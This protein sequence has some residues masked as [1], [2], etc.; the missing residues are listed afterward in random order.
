MLK[1]RIITAVILCVTLIPALFL[2]SDVAWATLV[3][4]I[5]LLSMYEWSKLT[6]LN[7]P[8]MMTAIFLFACIGVWTLLQVHHDSYHSFSYRGLSV[9]AVAA[10]FWLLLVPV[11][12][13]K[14]FEVRNKILMVLLGLLLLTSFLFA[15]ILVRK[16]DPWLLLVLLVTIWVADSAAYF[17]GKQF[18]KNKL[19]P[20]IS[21]GKTWE[22]VFGALVGVSAFA[23]ILY[24]GFGIKELA[25]FPTFWVMTLLGIMGDLFESLLKRQANVKDSGNMLPG[26]GGILDRIDGLIP[27]LPLAVLVIYFYHYFKVIS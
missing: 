9:F 8:A 13:A 17:S 24:F 7:L 23:A 4:I 15:L 11:W 21:P 2:L 27:S 1:T 16:M 22:G 3:V 19:A 12:L 5:C 20:T 18:G 6:Q 14:R 26:H 10:L 25:I